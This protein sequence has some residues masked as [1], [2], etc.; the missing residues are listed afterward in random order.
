MS[1]SKFES[2]L[3]TND[4][5]FFD[6]VEFETIIEHYLNIGKHSLAK[7]AVQLGLEQ[8]P[9]SIQ[10]KLMRVEILI[11]ENELQEAIKMLTKI[12][13]LEPH[14]DEVFI[15][16]AVIF[17]KKNKHVEA[18]SIL[19]ESLQYIE[20]PS[21]VWSMM[22]MEYL[23]LDDFENARLNFAKCIEVDFEDYSSLYNLV[24]CFDMEGSHEDAIRYLNAY[25]DKNPYCEVAWHQLGKQ[26][27]ELGMFKEA[28]T[29]FDY[30]VLI[31]ESFIGGYLEKAKTL[32]ELKDYEEAIKNYLITLELDDPT[33]FAYVRIGQCY[34][35]L[36]NTHTAM[37][38]YKK[39]VHEDPLLDRGWIMLTNVCYKENNYQKALYYINKAIQIDETNALYWRRYGDINLKLNFYEEA[40]KAF[41]T[42][43]DLG[44][45]EIEIYVAL[46]DILLFLGDFNE[47]LRRLI[48]AKKIY[49]EFAEVEYR[50]CG[51]FMIL[52]KEEYSLT[53]LKNALAIDYEYHSIVKELYPTVYENERVQK[54]ISNYK[55]AIR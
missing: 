1:L 51:L 36:K 42:C 26:Y 22:G 27:F 14:N 8:H 17:S 18:I 35:K 37:H 13:A 45:Q 15:Q 54:I 32:E 48:Q 3:K 21:D 5:Y 33:A 10:L 53:H 12:E 38:F 28:L 40:V 4:V 55:K 44:D 24:Y 31:D 34:E 19:K 39:A 20:D 9:T 7:K 52:E 50:L 2:M 49:K 16:K 43:I 6:A 46:A 23:Y 30:A 41:S 11:F 29:S 47:A 25:V